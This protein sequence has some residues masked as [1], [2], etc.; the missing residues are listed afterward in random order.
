M[1]HTP[2]MKTPEAK[3][4]RTPMYFNCVEKITVETKMAE[5]I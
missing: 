3:A 5:I 2:P 1:Q 4:K